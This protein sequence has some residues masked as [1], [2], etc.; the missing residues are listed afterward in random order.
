M[1]RHVENEHMNGGKQDD[2]GVDFG[3]DCANQYGSWGFPVR[4]T[5]NQR[6][7]HD[8]QDDTLFRNNSY[9]IDIKPSVLQILF[10]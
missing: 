1:N 9:A 6:Q 7:G 10:D 4:Y 5:W 2:S 8:K 3:S